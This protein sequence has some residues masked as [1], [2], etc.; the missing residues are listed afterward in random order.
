MTAKT[1][2]DKIWD[3]HVVRTRPKTALASSTSTV[4]S[5]MK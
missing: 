5:F 1:L 3:D 4:I 2:Y